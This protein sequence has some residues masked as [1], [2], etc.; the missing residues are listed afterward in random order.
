MKEHN[1]SREEECYKKLD[2]NKK[3][4]EKIHEKSQKMQFFQS[5]KEKKD[6]SI[7]L[8]IL[9]IIIFIVSHISK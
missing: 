6:R 4:L 1:K 7:Y 8:I 5:S 2:E 9:A 3:I